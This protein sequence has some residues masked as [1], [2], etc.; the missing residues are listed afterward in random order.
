M[1]SVTARKRYGSVELKPL[2][3][4]VEDDDDEEHKS[5]TDQWLTYALH[6]LHALLWII[7]AAA[8]AVYVQLYELIMDG[9]PPHDPKRQLNRCARTSVPLAASASSRDTTHPP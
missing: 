4:G 9:H 5:K 3:S 6:K 8:V 1:A 7:I 2:N